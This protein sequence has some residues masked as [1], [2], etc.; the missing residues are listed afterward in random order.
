MSDSEHV[1]ERSAQLDLLLNGSEE[2]Q[3]RAII[4]SFYNIGQGDPNSF[5]VQFAVF[6]TSH[7]RAAQTGD[8]SAK[9]TAPQFAAL[10]A[11][12]EK[13]AASIKNLPGRDDLVS[14]PDLQAIEKQVG[15]LAVAVEKQSVERPGDSVPATSG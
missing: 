11:M 10:K 4:E 7:A 1:P 6:L 2:G 3:R 5:A 15:Q 14:R 8:S 13:Q 12:L 9:M